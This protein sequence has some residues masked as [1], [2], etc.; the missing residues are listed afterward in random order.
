MRKINLLSIVIPYYNRRQLLINTLKSINYFKE[1]YPIEIIIVDD[2]S[3]KEHQINDITNLFSDLNINLIVVERHEIKWRG[4]SFAYNTGFNAVNGDVVL[5]NCAESFHAGNIIKYI[6][7]NLDTKS[8]MSFSTYCVDNDLNEIINNIDWNNSDVINKIDNFKHIKSFTNYWGSHSSN[9]TLIPYCAAINREDIEIL[10][11][12]D[13]RF[14]DGIGYDDYDLV[15]RINHL[16]LKTE[17][18]DKPYC[19]HQF[20]M[21]TTYSNTINLDF[22][23]YLENN[24]P[25]RIKAD[26][27]KIYI[28]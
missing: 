19:I 2:G 22:L 12:Y 16:K 15:Y 10:S 14:M 9:Y 11:G 3:S 5:I 23:H 24:Y 8:Y 25:N 27:N 21:P 6:F 17:L 7:N 1:K 20:H 13:E 18:I 26:M 28:K 4:A